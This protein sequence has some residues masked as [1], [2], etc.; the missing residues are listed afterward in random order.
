MGGE[1]EGK[2]LPMSLVI[3]QLQHGILPTAC[4]SGTAWHS[5][6]GRDLDSQ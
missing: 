2:G 4:G 3:R 1:S 6:L 5:Q